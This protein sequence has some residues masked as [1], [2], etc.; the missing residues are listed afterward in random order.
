M[1]SIEVKNFTTG[2]DE[3]ST[4]S[5]AR[6]ETVNV[7]GQ[8]VIKLTVQPGW[9]W[10]KDIKPTVGGDSCQATHLG[11]IVSGAVCAKH[12]DGTELTYKAGDAYSIQP[13]H[14]GWV[15]GNEPAIV[16]EFHGMWGE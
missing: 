1:A 14:D 12:N 13:G 3:I 7:G 6:V 10:S 4:P 15:V 2:A 8:R 11:V 16:Y 5:N 9:K